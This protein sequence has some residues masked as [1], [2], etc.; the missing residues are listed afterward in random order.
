MCT[1]T[2]A[3]RRAKSKSEQLLILLA[4]IRRSVVFDNVDSLVLVFSVWVIFRCGG[5][6]LV[7]AI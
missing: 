7:W 3:K 4:L 6:S 1:E 2:I 5:Y